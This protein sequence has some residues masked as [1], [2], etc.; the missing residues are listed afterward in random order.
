VSSSDTDG[1]IARGPSLPSP[2]EWLRS[3]VDVID[4]LRAGK[5]SRVFDA[6]LDGQRIALK[7]TESLLADRS[8]LASRLEAVASL[9]AGYPDVVQP[10]RIDGAFVQPIGDWLMTATTFI[11]GEQLDAGSADD[12]RVLGRSLAGLHAAMHELRPRE[13]PTIAALETSGLVGARSEW[14]LLHGD[15]GTQNVIVTPTMLRI[16][17][18]D[19]CGYGPIEYDVANSLYMEF[20]ES[21]V[22]G[23]RDADETFRPAFL[24]GYAEGSERELDIDTVDAMIGIRITA[25]GRWLADLDRAPIG[26][27]TSS[28]EWLETLSSFVRRNDPTNRR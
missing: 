8:A 5:Q 28:P 27:R 2:D 20:F 14:Q 6:V 1:V 22:T 4:E 13:I 7:L 25:L 17:D 23:H 15:F 9:G 16:F 26:I 19:D 11:E 24:A 10:I 3:R 21:D 18:F 12:A